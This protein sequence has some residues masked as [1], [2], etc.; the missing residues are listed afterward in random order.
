MGAE[1]SGRLARPGRP[2]A[3]ARVGEEGRR[4]AEPSTGT[5]A[6]SRLLRALCQATALPLRAA[7]ATR[8]ESGYQDPLRPPPGGPWAVG[9]SAQNFPGLASPPASERTPEPVPPRPGRTDVGMEVSVG[10]SPRTCLA[11]QRPRPSLLSLLIKVGSHSPRTA[12][13]SAPTPGYRWFAKTDLAPSPSRK[14]RAEGS[15]PSRARRQQPPCSPTGQGRGLEGR[16]GAVR[17]GRRP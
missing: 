16:R 2:P 4:S 11:P 5:A 10:R 13:A 17:G 14:I 12:A 9:V 6:R 7:P 1:G 8:S 15:P 3:A